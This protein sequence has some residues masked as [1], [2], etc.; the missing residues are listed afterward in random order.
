MK[1]ILQVV[2]SYKEELYQRVIVSG[3]LRTT[4]LVAPNRGPSK[5]HLWGLESRLSP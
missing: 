3:R 2:G 1:I 5:V 4:A